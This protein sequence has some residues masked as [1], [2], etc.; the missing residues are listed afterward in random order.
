MAEAPN[1]DTVALRFTARWTLN[2]K[3]ASGTGTSEHRNAAGTLLATGTLTTT[4]LLSFKFYGHPPSS[5]G[6]PSTFTAGKALIR[7]PST[8]ARPAARP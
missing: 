8:P 3:S 6:L 4:D 1:G 5:T 2:L 7:S